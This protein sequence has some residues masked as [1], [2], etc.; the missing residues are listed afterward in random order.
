MATEDFKTLTKELFSNYLELH[1]HMKEEVQKEI[2]LSY[3]EYVEFY[4][5][6]LNVI[7][8]EEEV[9]EEDEDFEDEEDSSEEDEE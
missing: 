1:K 7:A 3:K 5:S 4:L 2:N 8:V 6:Y 9:F